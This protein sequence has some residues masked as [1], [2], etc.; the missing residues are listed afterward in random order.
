MQE[1]FDF[2]QNASFSIPISTNSFLEKVRI[3][4]PEFESIL[5]QYKLYVEDGFID[6]ELLQ[7]SSLPTKIKDIPSLNEGKYIYFNDENIEMVNCANIFFSDQTGLT[8]VDPFKE[9]RYK[10]FFDLLS[11]EALK[12]DN[13]EEYQKSQL[14]YLIDKGFIKID[15][16]GFIEILNYERLFIF[17]DLYENEFGSF[18]HYTK[19]FQEEVL[20]M[21]DENI[22]Y[23]ESTLFAKTEQAYFNYFLNKSEF[24]N[25]LD[26]RNSYLH[27]TQG[28]PTEIE[29]HEFSYL[30]YLKLIVLTIFKI[31]DDLQI[32][33]FIE[34]NKR[35][36]G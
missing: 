26:L 20:K 17:K 8:Y 15:N 36:N 21:K 27:G 29:K 25:G 22:V 34:R 31:E 4:A 19:R 5:K 24:T 18:Y 1:K 2:P 32:F 33:T 35:T 12:F 11:N 13:Y 7:M 3:I 9:K 23:T 6:F 14:K 30:L 10:C 28:N 16:K